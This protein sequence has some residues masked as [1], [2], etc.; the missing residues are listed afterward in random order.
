MIRNVKALGLA[1]VAIFAMSAMVASAAQAENG[2]L[3]LSPGGGAGTK[4]TIKGN[5]VTNHSFTI[6]GVKVECS[7]VVFQPLGEYGT[8]ATSV[9]VHPVYEGCTSG[10]GTTI[11]NTENCNFT[12][13]ANG[14]ANANEEMLTW[15]TGEVKVTCNGSTF[16]TI[17]A[18]NVCVATIAT[19]TL[20]SGISFTNTTPNNTNEMAF[21]VIANK[22]PVATVKNVDGFG[23]PFVGTGSTTGE[24][25]GRTTMQC[26]E[27]SVIRVDC[28]IKTA[29]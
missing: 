1:L 27:G 13:M 18:A 21:D 10:I 19:Q 12:L 24:Y 25:T 29:P 22:A 23:C 6:A 26:F 5:Q 4:V 11:V 17:N 16:I 8:G 2:V 7:I 9:E 14:S 3:D 28:T 15:N 20:S